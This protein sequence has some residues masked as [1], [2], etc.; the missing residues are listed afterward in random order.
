MAT[1]A[2]RSGHSTN[3]LPPDHAVLEGPRDSQPPQ[4]TTLH[5]TAPMAQQWELQEDLEGLAAAA[6]TY[7]ATG[8]LG[9]EPSQAMEHLRVVT[10]LARP[11]QAR[12]AH[13]ITTG[14]NKSGQQQAAVALQHSHSTPSGSQAAGHPGRPLSA[15]PGSSDNHGQSYLAADASDRAKRAA[16]APLH[17]PDEMDLG[18]PFVILSASLGSPAAAHWG[19]ALDGLIH[20]PGTAC[21]SHEHAGAE[22]AHAYAGSDEMTEDDEAF[23][24]EERG[25]K[26]AGA[27]QQAGNGAPGADGQAAAKPKSNRG[28]KK[29]TEPVPVTMEGGQVKLLPPKEYRKYRRCDLS[30][31]EAADRLE[32]KH[33]C[34]GASQTAS[35][36]GGCAESVQRSGTSASRRYS[37]SATVTHRSGAGKGLKVACR[38]RACHSWHA[39][40]FGTRP[41]LVMSSERAT[42]ALG[43]RLLTENEELREQVQELEAENARLA[44]RNDQLEEEKRTMQLAA[45]KRAMQ[46]SKAHA[47]SVQ[48][49]TPTASRAP[50][51]HLLPQ[52]YP[53]LHATAAYPTHLLPPHDLH[54]PTHAQGQYDVVQNPQHRA[55]QPWSVEQP[56]SMQDPPPRGFQPPRTQ[57]PRPASNPIL[58]E[59]HDLPDRH[60]HHTARY[61][62]PGSCYGPPA[63]FSEPEERYVD[64]IER[65]GGDVS[66]RFSAL[67]SGGAQQQTGE[68]PFIDGEG[69]PLD[70]ALSHYHAY[71]ELPP[72]PSL[73]SDFHVVSHVGPA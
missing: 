56:R 68:L 58:S 21:S 62:E 61:A 44:V 60:M 8:E 64:P 55:P 38:P 37:P 66:G 27:A 18:A 42:L 32:E 24:E 10:S 14:Y 20:A 72:I 30:I 52:S 50:Q 43:N 34:A 16:S 13:I 53:D 26:H 19:I 2:Q 67:V 5:T 48:R 22:T 65:Y 47:G 59:L 71:Q 11:G 63:H 33:D 35:L 69:I 1:L 70:S 4:R 45:E 36:P 15:G 6:G 3:F 49:P 39:A 28:R 7:P 46:S 31:A 12:P 40:G 41:L 54:H 29:R 73:P 25:G 9:Q 51:P 57:R 23:D 17:S